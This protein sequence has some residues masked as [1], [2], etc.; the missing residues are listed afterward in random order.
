MGGF[1]VSRKTKKPHASLFRAARGGVY[2]KIAISITRRRRISVYA[3]DDGSLIGY[4]RFRS[5]NIVYRASG[6]GVKSLTRMPCGH[7]DRTVHFCN[8]N[9][10]RAIGVHSAR[11][12]MARWQPGNRRVRF[13]SDTKKTKYEC[14]NCEDARSDYDNNYVAG[15]TRFHTSAPVARSLFIMRPHPQNLNHFGIRIHYVHKPMLYVDAAGVDTRN[16]TN[17]FLKWRR[18]L[19][20]IGSQ[21]AQQS[22]SFRTKTG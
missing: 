12:P 17:E 19:K 16:V 7:S 6:M 20:W 18:F 4:C 5:L 8:G 10:S 15:N 9:S 13:S 2:F 21:D 11:K 14:Q 3:G 1:C 22:F